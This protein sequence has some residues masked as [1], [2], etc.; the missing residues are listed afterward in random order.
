MNRY[1]V[2]DFVCGNPILID[3]VKK[4]ITFYHTNVYG[5]V[6]DLKSGGKVVKGTA[7]INGLIK[8][9]NNSNYSFSNKYV[10]DQYIY[11]LLMSDEQKA[12]CRSIPQKPSEARFYISGDNYNE[13]ISIMCEQTYEQGYAWGKEKKTKEKPELT[14]Y[15][16]EFLSEFESDSRD[17]F[18]I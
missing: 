15:Y 16:K 17:L 14:A 6:Y 5:Q 1:Y 8:R 4:E 3:T 18:S 9:T 11:H 7:R 10:I 12:K 13:I 2:Y